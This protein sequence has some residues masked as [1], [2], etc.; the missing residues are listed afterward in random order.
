MPGNE[1]ARDCQL[2][3]LWTRG[4]SAL[5]II[6]LK[7]YFIVKTQCRCQKCWLIGYNE[8]VENLMGFKLN[9]ASRI[10]VPTTVWELVPPSISTKVKCSH[11]ETS[12]YPDGRKMIRNLVDYVE[13]VYALWT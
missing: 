12:L 9:F 2:D 5:G 10:L 8:N 1:A 4:V 3:R 6:L 11:H 7:L 13:G